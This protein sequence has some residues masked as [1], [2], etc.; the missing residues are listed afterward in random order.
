ME[1]FRKN[2]LK[3]RTQANLTQEELAEKSKLHRTTISDIER[4]TLSPTLDTMKKIADAL[5]LNLYDFFL[6][7][8]EERFSKKLYQPMDGNLGSYLISEIDSGEYKRIT[9]LSAYAKKSGVDRIKDVLLNFKKEGG[10]IRCIIGIDQMNTSYEALQELLMISDSL[11]IVHN[12]NPSYTY[13][14]KVYMLDKNIKNSNKAWLA[15]GSN[16]LTA[17]GLF[18]NYE[19]CVIDQLDLNNKI[20]KDG[21]ESTKRAIEYFLEAKNS[22]LSLHIESED[23]LDKLFLNKYIKKENELK[24]SLKNEYKDSDNNIIREKLFRSDFTFKAPTINSNTKAESPVSVSLQQIESKPIEITLE[25]SINET[26]WFEMR[27]STGGSRNILDLSSTAKLLYGTVGSEYVIKSSRS[28]KGGLL[29]FDLDSSEQTISKNITI[30][31]KGNE[32]YSSTILYA[33]NNQ[34][35]RLQLKGESS[36]DSKALSQYGRSD[37]VDKILAFTKISTNYYI[38]EI[39]DSNQLETLKKKS[40]FY[41]LN[42]HSKNS[43]M[44]G[45]LK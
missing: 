26:F 5:N 31:Y 27:K 37:F 12:E 25:E 33:K 44:F 19:S 30:S 6:L 2:L 1:N 9:I 23:I 34:S 24:L 45:K 39:L 36:S 13:H 11:T 14:S 16:N 43:K 22:N 10:E 40:I 38:L 20:D 15:I 32:Y 41:A 42:G 17:G 35:W 7:S 3:F 28:I 8:K 4:N 21:Y 18:I 29:F